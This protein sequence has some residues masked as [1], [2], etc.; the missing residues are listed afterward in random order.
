M[1][2]LC[3]WYAHRSLFTI[4]HSIFK[5]WPLFRGFKLLSLIHPWITYHTHKTRTQLAG[6]C[7]MCHN[8]T[9]LNPF[10]VSDKFLCIF[11]LFWYMVL[12]M[13][14]NDVRCAIPWN[15]NMLSLNFLQKRM[16]KLS[17]KNQIR[18][19]ARKTTYSRFRRNGSDDGFIPHH[20]IHAFLG[21][22]TNKRTTTQPKTEWRSQNFNWFPFIGLALASCIERNLKTHD[23]GICLIHVWKLK[24]WPGFGKLLLKWKCPSNKVLQPVPVLMPVF[25]YVRYACWNVFDTMN[26]RSTFQRNELSQ[27]RPQAKLSRL[28]YGIEFWSFSE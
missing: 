8:M 6:T 5:S 21:F 19:S 12:C 1:N 23:V 2:W 20:N 9:D 22:C 26:I 3:E 25:M 15:I 28:W 17:N 7:V 4:H 11:W 16:E 24:W 10:D 14:W 13:C 27:K 18:S